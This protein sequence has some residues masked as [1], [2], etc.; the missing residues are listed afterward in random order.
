[1]ARRSR[2][3]R[4]LCLG[5]ALLSGSAAAQAPRPAPAEIGQIVD[6]ALHAAVPPATHP[7]DV[8][9]EPP[10]RF[11]HGR[12]LAGFGYADDADARAALRVTRAVTDGSGALVE[13][14][15]YHGS[16]PCSRLGRSRYVYVEPT[17]VSDSEIAVWVHVSWVTRVPSGRSFKSS[18]STEVFLRR[19]GAGSWTFVRT[20]R[21]VIS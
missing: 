4:F 3:L 13:D 8:L 7:T 1:M 9:T 20:G 12:T 5:I 16:K 15:D 18:R 10:I 21:G 14:C 6:A 19:S 2:S 11:D 17:S